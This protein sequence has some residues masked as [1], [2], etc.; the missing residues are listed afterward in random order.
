MTKEKEPIFFDTETV[1]LHGCC[2]LIQWAVGDGEIHLYSVWT[3]PIIES[4]KL[5][6]MICN[7]PGGV[8]GFNLVFDWFHLTKIY[9]LLSC[10]HDLDANP[11]DIID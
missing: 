7:H 5:I 11:V 8:V 2:V 9:N 3:N 4:L 6:E 1:G 10:W